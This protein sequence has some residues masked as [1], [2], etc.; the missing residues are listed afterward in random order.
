[1]ISMI[2][3]LAIVKL[4]KV[5]SFN[6]A[7]LMMILDFLVAIVTSAPMLGFHLGERD[8]LH[9]WLSLRILVEQLFD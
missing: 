5:K 6:W 2:L 1:M 7:G 9:L 3:M 8:L 4:C